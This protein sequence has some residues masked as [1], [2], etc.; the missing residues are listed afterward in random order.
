MRKLVVIEFVTLDGVMQGLGSP[1][2]DRDGGFEHGGWAAPYFDDIQTASAVEGLRSTTAYLF[3]RRTYE[4]MTEFWPNQPDDNPMA[5]HLNATPKYVAS[6]TLTDF[7]W[8]NA[9]RLDGDLAPAVA[10][11]K[12][13]GDGT[14][15]VLGS[16]MLVQDLVANDLVDGYRLFLHPLLLGTGKRLFRETA[17]PRPLRLTSCTPTSTGVLLLEYEV[18]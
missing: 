15:A 7:T 11:L 17:R 4:K 13:Q 9:R 8:S 10:D 5:A 12:A 16:G 1:D 3:G 2:E 6:R 18:V 14:I